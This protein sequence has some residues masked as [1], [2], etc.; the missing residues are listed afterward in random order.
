MFALKSSSWTMEF[1]IQVSNGW[2]DR[3]A[4]GQLAKCSWPRCRSGFASRTDT[5][6][7]NSNYRALHT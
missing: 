4:Q 5:F 1:A 7:D 6:F 2:C 3:V